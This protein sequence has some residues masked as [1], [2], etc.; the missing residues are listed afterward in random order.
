MKYDPQT[1]HRQSIRLKNYDYS[2][3]GSYFITICTQDRKCLFGEIKNGVVN[4]NKIGELVKNEWLRTSEIR[5]NIIVD[6]F[7]IMPNHLHIILIIGDV[8]FRVTSH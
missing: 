5:P 8:N 4:L 2:Q 1:H 3:P 7:V 6:E